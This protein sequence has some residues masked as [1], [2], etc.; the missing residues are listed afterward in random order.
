MDT[1]TNKQDEADD[2]ADTGADAQDSALIAASSRPDDPAVVAAAAGKTTAPERG[3]ENQHPRPPS[4]L[5]NRGPPLDDDEPVERLA[6]DLL[7]GAEA[8]A[9]F[10]NHLGVPRPI[11]VY[12]LR[13]A[14]H[15]PIGKTGGDGA[16]GGKLIASKRRLTRHAEKI[17]RGTAA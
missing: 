5:H 17:T 3:T 7:V 11:D 16:K 9:A 13:R 1:T 4:R 15:W 10:L 8:I 2:R 6:G 14:G 12:Y